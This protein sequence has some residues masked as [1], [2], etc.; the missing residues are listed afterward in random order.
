MFYGIYHSSE[1]G[2]CSSVLVSVGRATT[3]FPP[4]IT[5]PCA[6]C[7]RVHDFRYYQAQMINSPSQLKRFN[8]QAQ[9]NGWTVAVVI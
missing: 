8:H 5:Y 7:D 2:N 1:S 3:N 9:H 4:S 6:W